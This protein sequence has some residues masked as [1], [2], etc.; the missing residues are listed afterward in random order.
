[1]R[2][3]LHDLDGITIINDAYNANPVSTVSSLETFDAVQ[4]PGRRVAVLG[5]MLE[6]GWYSTG[7]HRAVGAAVASSR[8]DVLVTVGRIASAIADG[9]RD[10]GF[11][12]KIVNLESPDQAAVYLKDHLSRGD[13]VLLKA[14]RALK[15]ERIIEQ[16]KKT[17]VA[18]TTRTSE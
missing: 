6:L 1:M 9:A 3:E 2:F 16:L 8:C 7:G 11:T 10:G 12:G 15:L 18:G 4:A 13:I 5:D 14:S 17:G